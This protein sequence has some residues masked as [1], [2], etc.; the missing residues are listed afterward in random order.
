MGFLDT[1]VG[2]Y[3]DMRTHSANK[4]KFKEALLVAVQDGKITDEEMESLNKAKAEYG[5]TDDD[6]KPIRAGMYLIAF[7]A[8]KSDSRITADEEHELKRIQTFLG[9][10][11][12][13]IAHTQ[14]DFLRLRLLDEIQRG[15]LP[16]RSVSNVIIQ[17]GETVYWAEYGTLLEER[18]T[19][20]RYVGGS[21]GMSFRVMK[22]VS[23]RVGASRGHAVSE[24]G[25]VPI[26]TGTLILTSKRVIFQGDRKSFS[27]K[28]D[29]ILDM[30]F[31][32]DG[33][34]L[35]E[36]NKKPKVI[37]YADPSNGE[38]VGM[39]LQH[40]INHYGEDS[41]GPSNPRKA[42]LPI[43]DANDEQTMDANTLLKEATEKKARDD[44]TGAVESLRQAYKAIARTDI[45][46]GAE[47]F[48]R[49]P[50]YLQAAGRIEEAWQVF[51]KLLKEGYPNQLHDDGIQPMDKSI[52]YDKMRV[53]LEREKRHN[54]AVKYAVLSHLSWG[55]GLMRQGRQNEFIK[56]FASE[57][58]DEKF[59]KMLR[60]VKKESLYPS[61]VD[62][63][64][65]HRE[66]I[67]DLDYENASK[68]LDML[69]GITEQ[70]P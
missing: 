16:E 9:I 51:Q 38:I 39:I 10:T 36:N 57:T 34:K 6:L 68:D 1:L 60:K 48:L 8:A 3:K 26:S 4:Q 40:A 15:N 23:Y 46:Y 66:T 55:L 58:L 41:H 20:T 13:E 42:A 2:K 31:Y 17:K 29:A 59:R 18:V 43:I 53:F 63:L 50:L 12:A 25:I 61:L 21:Q 11:D 35:A 47:T 69:L 65:K 30:Q 54:E 67:P 64:E 5:L 32:K 62:L 49:L 22:G 19:G 24:T 7:N 27:L 56:H 28:L 14:K 33:I 70:H 52:I 45:I 37:K 44:M